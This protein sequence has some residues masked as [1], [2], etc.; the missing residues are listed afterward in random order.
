MIPF[1]ISS[2]LDAAVN[3]GCLNLILSCYRVLIYSVKK[4]TFESFSRD[5]A[6]VW[7]FRNK[8]LYPV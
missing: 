1:N 2:T 5:V 3:K 7:I 8:L 6:Q 4:R